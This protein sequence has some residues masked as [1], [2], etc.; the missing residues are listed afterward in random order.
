M[1]GDVLKPLRDI[2]LGHRG[3]QMPF[4]MALPL[5]R[6]IMPKH[7]ELLRNYRAMRKPLA[8]PIN[9]ILLHQDPPSRIKVRQSMLTIRG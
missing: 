2:L 8:L 9:H 4:N 5:R 1:A 6:R 7:R 3:F